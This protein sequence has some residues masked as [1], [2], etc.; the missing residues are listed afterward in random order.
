MLR[1]VVE[2]AVLTGWRGHL[3]C[4]LLKCMGWPF[5]G[6]AHSGPWLLAVG[7]EQLAEVSEPTISYTL[8]PITEIL[9][10]PDNGELPTLPLPLPPTSRPRSP[11]I[12][13]CGKS[14]KEL[15]PRSL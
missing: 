6:T 10:E 4:A 12:S 1:E 14:L 5:L 2:K 3:L 9:Q 7:D 15:A 11:S 13:L 8:A